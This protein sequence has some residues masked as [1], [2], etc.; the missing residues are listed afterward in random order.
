LRTATDHGFGGSG[1]D[2]ITANTKK[3]GLPALTGISSSVSQVVKLP[4]H[5]KNRADTAAKQYDAG[6]QIKH[7]RKRQL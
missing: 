5:R 2:T 3:C 6:K 4:E 7:G 1:I